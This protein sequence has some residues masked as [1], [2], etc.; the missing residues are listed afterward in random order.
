MSSPSEKRQ[1]TR[2]KDTI[3]ITYR[4][5]KGY[6]QT[7][8]SSIDISEGGIRF[9]VFHKLDLG[10]PIELTIFLPN[11]PPI[12]VNGTVMWIREKVDG[13]FRFVVGVKFV[14]DAPRRQKIFQHLLKELCQKKES[15]KESK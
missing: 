4:T 2:I 14:E 6:L 12:I 9:P 5:P 10:S 11:N 15:K 13:E 7:E 8:S 1:F 3:K